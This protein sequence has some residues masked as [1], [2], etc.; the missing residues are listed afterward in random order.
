MAEHGVEI[1]ELWHLVNREIHDQFRHA[2]SGTDMLPI[3]HILL[4]TI[5]QKPGITV[6][7]VARRIGIVKSHVSK[8]VD[9]LVQQ[10][11]VEKRADPTDQ[12]LL[13]IY[14]TQE[15]KQKMTDFFHLAQGIWAQI[16]ADVPEEEQAGVVRSL[17]V[18]L[19]ALQ[20][21]NAR[22]NPDASLGDAT[23]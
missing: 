1:G 10:G 6:S 9:Q 18:L 22:Q 7:E 4:R 12:R 19:A 16:L 21:V 2:F 3:A 20:K 14:I 5:A 13:R 8:I 11:Y 17:E 23:R 15:A